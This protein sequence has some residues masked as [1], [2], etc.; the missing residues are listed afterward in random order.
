MGR[1]DPKLHR[2]RGELEIRNLWWEPRTKPTKKARAD[3]DEAIGRLS[4]FLEADRIV[5]PS[6]NKL[7]V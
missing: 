5:M 4:V 1:L 7:G 6:T 2:D 3:L